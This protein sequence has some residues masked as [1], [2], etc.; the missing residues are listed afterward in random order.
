MTPEGHALSAWITFSAY[1]DH[2]DTVVQVQA[3]ERHERPVHRACR[4]CSAPTGPTTGSGSA[5]SRTSPGRWASP[6]PWSIRE[7]C[8]DR[9]RQWKYARER[10]AQRRRAHGRRD[11]DRPGP[12]G[13]PAAGRG[14]SRQADRRH[15]VDRVAAPARCDRRRRRTQRPRGGDRARAGR[16]VGRGLEARRDGRRRHALRR[17][18]AARLRPRRLLGCPPARRSR[19]RSSGRSTSPPRPGVDRSPPRR[20]PP[21][22]R[23]PAVVLERVLGG[24]GATRSGADDAAAWAR[25]FGP[26]AARLRRASRRRS[27][28]R[29][30]TCRATRS[31]WPRFGLPALLPATALARLRLP[32]RAGAGA[33]RRHRRALDAAARRGR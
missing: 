26:L 2:D 8:V 25:L 27:C 7:G 23:R 9:R 24:H 33:V 1:R 3:L 20:R 21:V 15:G 16:A 31:C 22:R 19:R 6:R 12:L 29:S 30:C 5:R 11:R 4:T 14:L 28:G 32:R 13:A 17:A 18:D 10:A